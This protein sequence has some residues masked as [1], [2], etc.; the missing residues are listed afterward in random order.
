MNDAAIQFDSWAKPVP[1]YAPMPGLAMW[2]NNKL[3]NSVGGVS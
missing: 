3:F 1:T 2:P